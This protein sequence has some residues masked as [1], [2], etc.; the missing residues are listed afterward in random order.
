MIEIKERE[1]AEKLYNELKIILLSNENNLSFNYKSEQNHFYDWYE[2]LNSEI[3]NNFYNEK[4]SV[5]F[6]NNDGK[7]IKLEINR[8]H[9]QEIN[10][11]SGLNKTPCLKARISI[12]S[13]N[14]DQELWKLNINSDTIEAT[15]LEIPYKIIKPQVLYIQLSS[16]YYQYISAKQIKENFLL[17]RK[18]EIEEASKKIIDSYSK[19]LNQSEENIIFT[20]NILNEFTS[21]FFEYSTFNLASVGR[22]LQELVSIIEGDEYIYE[23][24]IDKKENIKSFIARK[25]N[26]LVKSENVLLLSADD[27]DNDKI[28]FYT[29]QKDQIKCN[30]DFGKFDYV[31]EFI[32]ELIQYRFQNNIKDFT[33][34][35][36]LRFM[37]NFIINH[38]DFALKKYNSIIEEKILNLGLNIS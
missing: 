17:K 16:L 4:G 26:N 24:I 18:K 13:D 20:Q 36:M 19:K 27:E 14:Q 21:L 9:P 35:D 25:D 23:Q 12:V 31:K 6:E 32:D 33:E 2:E 15:S 5:K 29:I 22:C 37:K 34:K 38:K 28:T 11:W 10:T 30:I 8:W 7:I 1:I 3:R